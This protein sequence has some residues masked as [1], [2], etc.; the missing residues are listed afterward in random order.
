MLSEA[1]LACPAAGFLMFVLHSR[2]SRGPSPW[3]SRPALRAGE[4]GTE[5][6]GGKGSLPGHA[7]VPPHTCARTRAPT[8]APTAPCPA[9]L[10]RGGVGVGKWRKSAPS[11]GFC[12]AGKGRCSEATFRFY[13]DARSLRAGWGGALP[14]PAPPHCHCQTLL[15]KQVHRSPVQH[16]L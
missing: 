8:P 13:R 4:S 10:S 12:A 6:G 2:T 3:T 7:P 11:G 14:R 1:S 5:G 9:E 16:R 15:E